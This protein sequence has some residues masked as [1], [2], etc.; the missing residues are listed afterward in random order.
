MDD[1]ASLYI[2]YAWNVLSKSTKVTVNNRPGDI[3][4]RECNSGI[5]STPEDDSSNVRICIICVLVCIRV[6]KS[7]LCLSSVLFL[8]FSVILVCCVCK[9]LN[10]N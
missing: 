7:R 2:F 5:F 4:M 9:K 1:E 8:L 6:M 3:R 10:L